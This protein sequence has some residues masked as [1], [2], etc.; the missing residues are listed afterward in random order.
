[1]SGA[2]AGAMT[3]AVAAIAAGSETRPV[4][5]TR[6]P[7]PGEYNRLFDSWVNRIDIRSLLGTADLDEHK[8]VLSVLDSTELGAIANAALST[9]K[10]TRW[11]PYVED[12]LAII[13]TVANLRGVP[14][15]FDL[16]GSSRGTHYGMSC[17]ADDMRF[18]V[19]GAGRTIPNAVALDPKDAPGG[20]WPRLAA[21][22]LASG[23]FPIGLQS[24]VLDRPPQDYDS[25]YAPRRPAWSNPND[26][27]RFLCVDGGLMNN[28]PLELARQYLAGGA[29]ARNPRE[30]EK[31]RRAVIMVDPFPNEA[32]FDPD[33][34]ADDR[35]ATV[36][37]R[38]FGAMINQLRFKPEE[39][40]LAE[41]DRVFSRYSITPSRHD[42]SGQRDPLAIASGILGGF[43]GFL[44]VEF[45]RHDFQ[46]GR[47]N[48]QAFLRSHFALPETNPLFA[49]DNGQ[50]ALKERFYVKDNQG[51]LMSFDTED[52]RRVPKLPIIPLVGDSARAVPPPAWPTA[53]AVDLQALEAQIANRIEKLGAMAVD[54][55][56]KALVPG[57][58]LR[59][60][61]KRAWLNFIAPRVCART[62]DKIRAELARL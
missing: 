54:T 49:A 26:P 4:M 22:A 44:S 27:Y 50:F 39:L 5:D 38:M 57:A 13:L 56:L 51:V 3:S 55:D 37:A 61:I 14:Y 12:P 10:R 34:V 11:R 36:V 58:L 19:S 8:R 9:A 21:A 35:L 31:A 47:R 62:M 41:D 40:E 2:S 53:G 15:E 28:E 45:R 20:N 29:E 17:H 52:G 24:R 25:R 46:L 33:W 6:Q 7:P 43:G 30:G 48:C 60:G 1:M 32:G 23:A 42:A 16:F 59:W 18:A